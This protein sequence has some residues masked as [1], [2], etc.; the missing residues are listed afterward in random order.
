VSRELPSPADLEIG[1]EL[2]PLLRR[3]GWEEIRKFNRYA[4]GGRDT[5]NIHTDDETA[6]RAGL[7]RAVAT[8]RHPVAFLAERMVD[9]FGTGFLFGGEIDVSFLKPIFPG[10]TL[11]V[12]GRVRGK[13]EENGKTRL[14][15]EVALLNQEGAPVTAGTASG[16][17]E[18]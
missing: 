5:Q 12:T 18:G 11:E 15:L 8:G 13:S 16:L 3:M 9:L 2:P 1:D 4:T 14:V 10:D 17:I 6:R 7:P